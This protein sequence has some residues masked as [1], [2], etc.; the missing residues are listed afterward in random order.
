MY[1]NVPNAQWSGTHVWNISY[2]IR[3]SPCVTCSCSSSVSGSLQIVAG[4]PGGAEAIGRTV[5]APLA[6]DGEAV[7]LTV[8]RANVS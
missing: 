6:T 4:V 7:V 8:D 5:Q 1:I 3:Q 2:W